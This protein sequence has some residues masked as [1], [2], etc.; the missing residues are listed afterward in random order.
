MTATIQCGE[1]A[2]GMVTPAAARAEFDAEVTYLDTATMGL[3]PRR[4]WLALQE[5]LAEWRAGTADAVGYDRPLAEARCSYAQLV[6][7]HPSAVAVGSQ[8]SVFAGLIAANLPAGS[9]VLTAAGDFTSILFPFLAQSGRGVTVRRPAGR[10]RRG[11]SA[12]PLPGGWPAPRWCRR[13]SGYRPV[14]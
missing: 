4:G 1:N 11:W 14:R 3:P 10:R 7:V 2:A 8:V 12:R 6:G 5:A 9:E 13:W